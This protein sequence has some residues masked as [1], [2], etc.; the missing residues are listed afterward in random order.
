MHSKWI[1]SRNAISC[2]LSSTTL[3]MTSVVMRSGQGRRRRE[4]AAAL[5]EHQL[6]AG[7]CPALS[8]LGAVRIRR[9]R[10]S[11]VPW[12]QTA[13]SLP[14]MTFEVVSWGIGKY[15]GWSPDD[16]MGVRTPG[17]RTG[18]GVAVGGRFFLLVDG[19]GDRAMGVSC[20]SVWVKLSNDGVI[21]AT[22]AELGS[23]VRVWKWMQ[24]STRDRR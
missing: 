17:W 12:R 21:F 1:N 22:I 10:L 16:W 5:K 14:C 9:P 20:R 7:L 15:C 19:L 24:M 6:A 18:I 13:C 2:Y 23:R 11:L 4:R 3:I 8:P